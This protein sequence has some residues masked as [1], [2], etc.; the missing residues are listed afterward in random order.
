VGRGHEERRVQ[1]PRQP[2]V[3]AA[4]APVLVLTFSLAVFDLD[5][6]LLDS[7]AALAAPY[8]ALGVPASEVTYGHVVA[9]ECRRLG[10][11]IDDYVA[12]YDVDAAQPYPGVDAMVVALDRWG[13][14]S[15]KVRPSG[16]AELR[17]LGWE[18]DVA[19]FADDFGG[20]PKQLGP[21]LSALG[22]P[23]PATVVF[24][25]DTDHDRAC[26]RAVGVTFALAAWNPRAASLRTDG[27]VVLAR[28]ADL[29]PLL[30]RR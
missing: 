14:C 5:G 20:G 13:V 27:D 21:V 23:D 15:N 24:V 7:D 17:R 2:V 4:A 11:S 10:L 28:P 18:P 9:D 29:L 3:G 25:G 22:D 1:G 16:A 26:A 12:A 8:V 19:L 30:D 6:T